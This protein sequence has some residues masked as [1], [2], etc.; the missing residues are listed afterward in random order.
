MTTEHDPEA[1][2]ICH[3]CGGSGPMILAVAKINPH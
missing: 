2:T 3:P 1:K